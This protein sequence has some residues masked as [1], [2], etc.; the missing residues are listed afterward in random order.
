VN[1]QPLLIREF[2]A[3]KSRDLVA[4][5]SPEF[6]LQKSGPRAAFQKGM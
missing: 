5:G 6:V 4:Y 3:E 2:V 1:L